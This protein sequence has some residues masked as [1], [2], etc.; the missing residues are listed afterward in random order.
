MKEHNNI[1]KSDFDWYIEELYKVN[2]SD[3]N[4][5][6]SIARRGLDEL[7]LLNKSETGTILGIDIVTLLVVF[8]CII[9]GLCVLLVPD[10]NT[11]PMYLFGCLF[12]FAGL[13]VG[14][15]VPGFGLIFLFTH[16]GTG[17]AVMICSLLGSFDSNDSIIEKIFNNPALTDGG[18][19]NNMYMYLYLIGALF[20][21][22]LVYTILYNLS[23]KLKENKIHI[24]V[25]LAIFFVGILLVGL[26]PRIFGFIN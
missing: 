11:S 6:N 3:P 15:S 9:I 17:L 25:I 19:Q 21:T 13:A 22:A 8:L 26:L 5:A 18:M 24:V 1:N 2:S 10:M 20:V 12:F 4:K 23:P 14:F 16:G 7:G